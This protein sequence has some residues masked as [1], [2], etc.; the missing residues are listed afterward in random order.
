[1]RVQ[2]GAA[3]AVFSLLVAST[4]AAAPAS[5]TNPQPAL[6]ASPG[7]PVPDAS[8]SSFDYIVVGAGNA[9]AVVAARCVRW[10]VR[11]DRSQ[12]RRTADLDFPWVD[13]IYYV[14]TRLSEDPS[15]RVLLLE[16]GTVSQDSQGQGRR[17]DWIVEQIST[18]RHDY[19]TWAMPAL[20]Q[21][22]YTEANPALNNRSGILVG[23][24]VTGKALGGSTVRRGGGCVCAVLCCA[25]LPAVMVEE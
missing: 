25:V 16:E 15:V 13:S 18:P 5:N 14:P 24:V 3:A 4:A 23:P 1:M 2:L 19:R 6:R 9:G 8:D 10:V 17:P 12:F 22:I 21:Q 11:V 7:A 20:T